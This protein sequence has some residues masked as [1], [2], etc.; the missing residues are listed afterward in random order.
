MFGSLDNFSASHHSFLL[1]IAHIISDGMHSP[2]QVNVA[3]SLT[4]L[5]AKVRKSC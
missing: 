5:K 4:L 2:L 1:L 3:D